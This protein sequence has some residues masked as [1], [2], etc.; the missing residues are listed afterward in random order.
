MKTLVINPTRLAE[1]LD[2][3][4][5]PRVEDPAF[6]DFQAGEKP[7]PL[8]TDE[9]CAMAIRLV[10]VHIRADDLVP[11][12]TPERAADGTPTGKT[13]PCLG[14]IIDTEFLHRVPIGALVPHLPPFHPTIGAH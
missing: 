9:R 11:I 3:L 10:G 6:C 14:F 1:L 12:D 13:I 2:T 8:C 4:K 5:I 7:R